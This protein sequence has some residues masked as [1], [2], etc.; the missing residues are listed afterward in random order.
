V[1]FHP[2]FAATGRT[3]NW[4]D[5]DVF[6]KRIVAVAGGPAGLYAFWEPQGAEYTDRGLAHLSDQSAVKA[7]RLPFECLVK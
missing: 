7:S 4:F 3:R 5:D 1:I 6:I 2:S